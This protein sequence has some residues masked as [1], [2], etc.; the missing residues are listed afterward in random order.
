MY[1]SN[2]S[3]KQDFGDIHGLV[4]TEASATYLDPGL[5]FGS[6]TA[7]DHLLKYFLSLDGIK[8]L[9][10]GEGSQILNH[11][12]LISAD[13][14]NALQTV[15]NESWTCDLDST[16]VINESHALTTKE[17]YS[18]APNDTQTNGSLPPQNSPDQQLCQSSKAPEDCPPSVTLASE[19]Q[20]KKFMSFQPEIKS[21][22]TDKSFNPDYQNI[23][24]FQSSI[25]PEDYPPSVTPA[26]DEQLQKFMNLQ[27]NIQ[28][29]YKAS[30]TDDQNEQSSRKRLASRDGNDDIQP[31]L[32]PDQERTQK[33]SELN[34]S[35][36]K[37]SSFSCSFTY[38]SR[39]NQRKLY[40]C[41][42]CSFSTVHLT[43]VGPH[44]KLHGSKNPLVCSTCNYSTFS[45]PLFH[46]HNYVHHRKKY[47]KCPVCSYSCGLMKGIAKHT[48][49]HHPKENVWKCRD[50]N[51]ESY[52]MYYL[53]RHVKVYHSGS[54]PWKCLEC[55]FETTHKSILKKHKQFHGLNIF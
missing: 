27:P 18:S 32:Q 46:H 2:E 30:N 17:C 24:L 8:N 54:K 53:Q 47:Y 41:K 3:K 29:D 35:D 15:G 6:R 49:D 10:T 36:T 7:T 4:K 40:Q 39:G 21:E 1:K 44:K 23:Q 5:T 16:S 43:S 51:Y 13:K 20:I 34:I 52:S 9:V 11:N 26:S 33:Q 19:E 45:Q 12:L 37:L 14:Y 28:S 48:E 50:C 38:T 55:A 42:Q 22:S 31:D 25:V